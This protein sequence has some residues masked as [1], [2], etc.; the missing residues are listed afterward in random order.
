VSRTVENPNPSTVAVAIGEL[1][2]QA[3]AAGHRAGSR[4]FFQ[5][6]ETYSLTQASIELGVA[7]RHLGTTVTTEL[8][9][10]ESRENRSLFLTITKI[11]DLFS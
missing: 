1:I 4:T 5:Q 7:A 2:E 8:S 6:M 3:E 9:Y 11:E 10:D